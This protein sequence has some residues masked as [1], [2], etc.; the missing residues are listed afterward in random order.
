MNIAILLKNNFDFSQLSY[1]A[2]MQINNY[3]NKHP[4]HKITVCSLNNNP[5]TFRVNTANM[6]IV[7]MNSFDGLIITTCIDTTL[8]AKHLTKD[9]PIIH[10]V[11]DLEWIR[12]GKKD[13]FRNIAAYRRVLLATRSNTHAM[14]LFKYSGIRTD[15]VTPNFNIEYMVNAYNR[16]KSTSS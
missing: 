14:Q 8:F 6:S 3:I 5:P 15:I 16:I 12:R 2:S 11:W 4:D 1:N 13:Y 10:Y 9:N 7:D